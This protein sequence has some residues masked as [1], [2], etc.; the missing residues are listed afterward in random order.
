MNPSPE[1]D[2]DKGAGALF[3]LS[4]VLERLPRARKLIVLDDDPTG[5]QPVCGIPVITRWQVDDIRWALRAGGSGFYI[6]TNTRS[7]DASQ[8]GD[9]VREIG[10]HCLAAARLEDLDVTL[11]SRGDSTLRG[12]FPLEVTVIGGLYDS[13]SPRTIVLAPSYIEAGRITLG[14]IHYVVTPFGRVPAGE[15][16]FATDRTFGYR[17]S[18]LSDWVVEKTGGAIDVADIM[19]VPLGYLRSGGTSLA[20]SIVTTRPRV[21]IADAESDDDIRALAIA[22][23]DAEAAGTRILYQVGPSFV[24]AR[25]G[26][27]TPLPLSRDRL[28]RLVNFPESHGL[29]VV[30]SHVDLTTRQVDALMEGSPDVVR[31]TLDVS[32]ILSPRLREK[33]INTVVTEAILALQ[34]HTV[35][36]ETSRTL[37][38][39]QDPEES[40]LISTTVSKALVTAVH[41]V[42]STEKPAYII[43]KGGITSSDIATAALGITRAMVEGPLLDGI[44][45]LW[46]PVEGPVEGLPYIVFAGN[47]GDDQSLVRAVARMEEARSD[48]ASTDQK[49]AS[50]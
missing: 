42:V 35:L 47:V 27:D 7:L 3:P 21:V 39:G 38:S 24:R 20:E 45:S 31:I 4:G 28:A 46:R 33:H 14:G 29:V 2:S 19:E 10:R 30:G 26:Q 23:M 17:S 49:A 37:Q 18:R 25:L 6:L 43:A 15:T 44:I 40:L 8:A 41:R 48:A 1:E 16:E 5:T 13:D 36:I 12:H 32:Q 11:V 22:T 9:R 50:Q 34:T